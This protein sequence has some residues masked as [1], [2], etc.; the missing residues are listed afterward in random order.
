MG[1][2]P[3]I[4]MG[5]GWLLVVAAVAVVTFVVVDRAGR[6]VGQASA[7]QTVG[8]LPS[9]GATASPEATT[10]PTAEPSGSVPTTT[11]GPT[12]TPAAAEL[13]TTSFTTPGGTVVASCAGSVLS[14]GSITVR[15]G[16]RFERES[17]DQGLEVKFKSRASDAED[18]EIVLGC[19]GGVPTRLA[20]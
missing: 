14:L 19:V 18:V 7:A 6:E 20:G 1:R 3:L 4:A 9:A 11:A 12:P 8:A 17:E 5:L 13:R 2:R 10:T 16:W 15:D